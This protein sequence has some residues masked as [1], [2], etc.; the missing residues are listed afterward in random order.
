MEYEDCKDDR[1]EGK[2]GKNDRLN[3]KESKVWF[4]IY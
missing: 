1:K 2:S 4:N 3:I